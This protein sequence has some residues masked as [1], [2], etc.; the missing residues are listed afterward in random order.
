MQRQLDIHNFQQYVVPQSTTGFDSQPCHKMTVRHKVEQNSK[1]SVMGTVSL[2][3]QT[4]KGPKKPK[5]SIKQNHTINK[6][7]S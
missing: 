7:Y 4:N 1:Y 2:K 6:K 5:K 3:P